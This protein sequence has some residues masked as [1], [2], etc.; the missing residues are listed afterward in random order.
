MT[1]LRSTWRLSLYL[2]ASLG[3]FLLVALPV[4]QGDFQ[5][6]FYVDTDTYEPLART[7]PLSFNLISVS[8]NLFGPVLILKALGGNRFLVYLF[9]VACLAAAYAVVV[10]TFAV[11]RLRFLFYLM[12]TPLML[13]S[14]LSINKEIVAVAAIAFF[15]ASLHSGRRWQLLVALLMSFLVRWQMTLFMLTF[16]ALASPLNPWRRRRLLSVILLTAAISVVYVHNL[17]TFRR[18]DQVALLGAQQATEGSGLYHVFQTVQ[19][20]YGYILVFIPKT[21]HQMV[22]PISRVGKVTEVEN[23]F[24]NDVIFSHCVAT[25]ILLLVALWRRRIRLDLDPIYIA[26]VYAAVFGLSPI[27]SPRYFLPIYVLVAIAISLRPAAGPASPAA[28]PD[29]Q[30]SLALAPAGG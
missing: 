16:M 17:E 28:E 29:G 27:F 15:A 8:T 13:T 20:H 18:L 9:N 21:L 11:H 5:L 14:L 30:P 26:A 22:G 23:F 3:A 2:F 10:R 1:I 7:M 12:L 25:A 6:E 4:L 19:N 24:N